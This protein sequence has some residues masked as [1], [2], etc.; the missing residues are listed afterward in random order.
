MLVKSWNGARSHLT[1]ETTINHD[2][3][4]YSERTNTKQKLTERRKTVLTKVLL[5]SKRHRGTTLGSRIPFTGRFASRSSFH[6]NSL[7]GQLWFTRYV[8]AQRVRKATV[9]THTHITCTCSGFAL[10]KRCPRIKYKVTFAKPFQR[11]YIFQQM[12]R[13]ILM[14]GRMRDE[15]DR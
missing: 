11:S 10:S 6:L 9:T 12:L 15:I 13:R 7:S 2:Y 5:Q 14:A 1:G 4:M 8:A 3:S